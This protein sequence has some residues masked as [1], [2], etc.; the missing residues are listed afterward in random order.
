MINMKILTTILLV[1]FFISA[2]AQDATIQYEP[3]YIKITLQTKQNVWKNKTITVQNSLTCDSSG[4]V[5][6]RNDWKAC[7]RSLARYMK[8]W[9]DIQVAAM[10]VADLMNDDGSSNSPELLRQ[11]IANYKATLNKYG[12]TIGYFSR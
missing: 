2:N 5:S 11:A 4:S 6:Y 9:N 7:F 8:M 1:C 3:P 10:R 12:V